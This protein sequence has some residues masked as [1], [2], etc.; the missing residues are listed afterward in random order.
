MW[1]ALLIMGFTLF[2]IYWVVVGSIFASF[3]FIRNM[4]I[5]KARFG[6]LFSSFAL[7]SAIAA[8]YSGYYFSREGIAECLQKDIGWSDSVVSFVGCSMFSISVMGIAWFIA[9]FG[10][11]FIALLLSRSFNQSWMDHEI[12]ND[13]GLE[14]SYENL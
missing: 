13:D 4:K 10:F 3:S 1:L 11:G 7:F 5:K 12:D 2:L 9:L 14:F 6:C 8:T